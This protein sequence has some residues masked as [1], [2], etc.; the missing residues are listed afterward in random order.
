MA[1]RIHV[2]Q[3]PPIEQT[4]ADTVERIDREITLTERDLIKV[5]GSRAGIANQIA[6]LRQREMDHGGL[7]RA[8][9]VRV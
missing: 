4:L 8:R 7:E 5:A 6:E 2:R 9:S 3:A 1:R